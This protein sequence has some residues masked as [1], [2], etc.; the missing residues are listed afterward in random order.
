[1]A[2]EVA[3][4]PL[5]DFGP[6]LLAL[7]Q[8]MPYPILQSMFD[9]LLPHGLH[10]YWKSDFVAE[11]TDEAIAEHVRFGPRIPT[12]HSAMHIYPMDGAVD[13]TA[14]DQTAFAYRDVKFV[15]IIA[16]VTPDPAALPAHREWV[17]D[18][19]TALH[20]YSAAGTY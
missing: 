3:T 20:P 2:A 5:R 17:G 4:K 13:D 9:P 10:H 6:P 8:P 7:T 12:I 11:L 18:Y 16:A 14:R 19:W 1:L 15:H